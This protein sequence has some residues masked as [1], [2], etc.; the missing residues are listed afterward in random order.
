MY[1][2]YFKWRVVGSQLNEVRL[3]TADRL[4]YNNVS[5]INLKYQCFLEL[6]I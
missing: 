5:N 3:M 1:S 4:L 2:T 6:F